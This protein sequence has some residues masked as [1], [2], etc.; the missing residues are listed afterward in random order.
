MNRKEIQDWVKRLHATETHDLAK[1]LSE[2]D[3]S[4]YPEPAFAAMHQ[5]LAGRQVKRPSSETELLAARR[6]VVW[7]EFRALPVRCNAAF[8]VSGPKCE[9]NFSEKG[10]IVPERSGFHDWDD[11][12]NYVIV[13]FNLPEKTDISYSMTRRGKYQRLDPKGNPIFT[14][15]DPILDLVTDEYGWITIGDE[16]YNLRTM[17][18]AVSFGRGGGI[19]SVD[20]TPYLKEIQ[21]AQIA[22]AMARGEKYIVQESADETLQISSLNPKERWFHKSGASMRFRAWKKDYKVYWSMGA[23]IETWGGNFDYAKIES[24]YGDAIAHGFCAT[25][26]HDWDDDRN[27]DYVDEWEWGVNSSPPTGVRSWCTANWKGGYYSGSVEA[28]GCDTFFA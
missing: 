14:F 19:R 13:S 6:N 23:E 9:I 18:R 11:L 24:D 2:N 17:P 12:L 7:S 8:R 27:D 1:E 26:K 25:M 16:C 10:F 21:H 15:G 5:L 28:G 4:K 20:L 22:E 3:S